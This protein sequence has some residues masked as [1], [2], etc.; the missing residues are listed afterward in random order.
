MTK[1]QH[2]KKLYSVRFTP[3]GSKIGNAVGHKGRLVPLSAAIKLA[4]RL[5]RS[6]VDADISALMVSV[7]P[8]Q[9]AYLKNRYKTKASTVASHQLT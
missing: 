9:A 2:F 5:C 4:K 3:T 8:S 6:G 1:T 7:T